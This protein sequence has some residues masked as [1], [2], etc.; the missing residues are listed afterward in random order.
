MRDIIYLSKAS[1][2]WI[3]LMIAFRIYVEYIKS[4]P[5]PWKSQIMRE[6]KA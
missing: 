4:D 3:E 5:R 2:K 1:P 6:N